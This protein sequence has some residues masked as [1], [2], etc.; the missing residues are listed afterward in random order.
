[1]KFRFRC[2]GSCRLLSI[3]SRFFL[4][5]CEFKVENF[6]EARDRRYLPSLLDTFPW[7]LNLEI[8]LGFTLGPILKSIHIAYIEVF[9][10]FPDP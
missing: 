7:A 2:T 1:M 6:A 4:T 9:G 8:G 3:K 5:K 10:A